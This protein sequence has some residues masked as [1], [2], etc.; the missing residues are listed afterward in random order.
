MSGLSEVVD[1][2]IVLT[3]RTITPETELIIWP[4][5]AIDGAI[6]ADSRTAFRIADS[7]RSWNIPL[8]TGTG[9]FKTYAPDTDVLYRGIYPGI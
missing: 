5:N 2:L 7:T 8:I 6:F 9:L 3:E 1:S 4:E